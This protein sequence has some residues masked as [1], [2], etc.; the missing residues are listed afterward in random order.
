MAVR[1]ILNGVPYN[2]PTLGDLGWGDLTSYLV[3]LP[4]AVASPISIGSPANGLSL[5][6]STLTLAS[7]GASQAGA[8]TTGTQSFAGNKTFT[9]TIAASNLSGTNTGDLALAAFGSTPSGFGAILTGQSLALQPAD[10]SNPGLV[11]IAAQSFSGVKTFL[12]GVVISSLT[13]SNGLIT[14][15]VADG[16]SSIAFTLNSA[17]S[18][19]TSGAKLLVLENNGTAKFTVDKDGNTTAVGTIAASNFSGTSSGTNTGDV[20]LAAVGSSPSANGASLAAQVLTLQ[21]ADG[22][23]PGVITS[24]SQSIGG[25]K[26]FG[27]NIIFSSTIQSNSFINDSSGNARLGFYG[28]SGL[29]SLFNS[30]VADGA[31]AVA[32]ISNAAVALSTAGALLVSVRNNSV[33][34]FKIDKDGNTTATGTIG[35]SNFS[36]TSS[37]TN[38]GDV[39]LSAFGSTPNGNGASLSTQALTLQPADGSNPGGVSTTTQTFAGAKTFSGAVTVASL[40]LSSST[41]GNLI[42]N[43]SDSGANIAFVLNSSGA[44]SSAKL[45]SVQNNGTAKFEVDH[46]GNGTFGGPTVTTFPGNAA[47]GSVTLHGVINNQTGAAVG[48]TGDTNEDTLFTYTMPANAFNQAGKGVRVTAWGSGVNAGTDVVTVR[49]YFGA[50]VV[51]SKVLTVSQVNTWRG[52]Y[53]CFQITAANTQTASGVITNGGTAVSTAMNATAIAPAATT[54]GTIVIK[55]TG[56]RATTA[57]SNSVVAN[58]M[59]VEFIN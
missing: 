53:E 45:M 54:S 18:F 19:A 12:N 47:S 17:N 56:Q 51:V 26:T 34:K 4:S 42:S 3:A 48:N 43:I 35:A 22:T 57:L 30:F 46:S 39:T 2:I 32:F 31:S 9:G 24:G 7:A 15:S 52:V 13:L 28:S 27:S 8:V 1:V 16:P 36:G 33:E 58:G 10:G 29:G 44:L 59:I 37:G 23:H 25:I 49:M 41:I 38:S 5:V 14:S 50:T 55:V 40:T 21:P 6:S 20:S 11:S